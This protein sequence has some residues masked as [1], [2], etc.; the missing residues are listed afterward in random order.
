MNHQNLIL[1]AVEMMNHL[2]IPDEYL[3]G[4]IQSHAELLAGLS[5]DPSDTDYD[6]FH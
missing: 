3:S 5:A 2:D 6:I 1:Q 4:A